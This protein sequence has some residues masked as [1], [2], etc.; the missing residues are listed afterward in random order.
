MEDVNY[1]KDNLH[2]FLPTYERASQVD[3]MLHLIPDRA[4]TLE[5]QRYQYYD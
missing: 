2:F 4:L 3:T 5:V 1:N